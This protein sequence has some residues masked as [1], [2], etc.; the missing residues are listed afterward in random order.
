MLEQSR[1][2]TNAASLVFLHA[3]LD[4]TV[5]AL[6]KASRVAAPKEWVRKIN[7]RNVTIERVREQGYAALEVEH[8]D[9]FVSQLEKESLPKKADTLL[10]F[11]PPLIGDDNH[12]YNRDRLVALDRLR[13]EVVHNSGP[14]AIE[15]IEDDCFFLY[16]TGFMLAWAVVGKY[17]LIE[18]LNP[19]ALFSDRS[20]SP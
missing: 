17:D 5:L 10:S 14:I 18:L 8:L 7:K 12:R 15:T 19:Y 1:A 16:R 11:C 9:K 3:A 4:D 6:C 13:H 2:G 20:G